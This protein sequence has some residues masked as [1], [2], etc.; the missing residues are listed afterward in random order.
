[1]FKKAFQA[2]LSILT[3]TA[4]IT[5][6]M[7]APVKAYQPF[8]TSS[9]TA[10]HWNIAANATINWHLADG[11]PSMAGDSM[12]AGL[13]S[14]SDATGA[15]FTF[16]QGPGGVSVDWDTDGSKIPDPTYLAYTTFNADSTG[17]ITD[18]HIVVNA[19][20]Y[21]WHRGGFGGVGPTVNGLRD[22]NLD[23]VM[24]HELG[25][26]LGLDHSDKNPAA[27]VGTAVIGDPPTMNSVVYPGAGSLHDDDKAGIRSIYDAG[28]HTAPS[29]IT[30]N[31]S[32][33]QGTK[34]P[35]SVSFTQI[36]GDASTTW[37]FGDGATSTGMSAQHNFTANGTYTV[38]VDCLGTKTTTTILVGSKAIHAAK[39]AAAKA[40]K[41]QQKQQKS[42]A[43]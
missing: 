34:A 22:A 33:T 7:S 15:A 40:A 14:W 26:A 32:V 9:N 31:P 2:A 43:K 35:L 25:H 19:H 36:G 10:Y 18:A 39:T 16:A 20:N 38:T 4:M 28:V 5:W 24:L 8:M 6:A 23:S 42:T 12:A 11:V 29:A 13:Q 27:L 41:A 37:D 1:M 3:V 30:V 21:T 17:R